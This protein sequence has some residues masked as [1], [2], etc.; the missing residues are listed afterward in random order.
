MAIPHVYCSLED[1]L[2]QMPEKE[3]IQLT[4][5]EKFGHL[6]EKALGRIQTAIQ[7]ITSV[8]DSYARRG[9]YAVPL[10]DEALARRLAKVLV[11]CALQARRN[12]TQEARQKD[13]EA[14]MK[15]L[16]SLAKGETVLEEK[17]TSAGVK[18]DDRSQI[19]SNENLDKF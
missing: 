8:I 6:H 13:Y 14:A 10:A 5:D 3:L 17:G 16:E 18:R 11:V 9:G 15:T 2:D 4:D 7:E 19:F 1:L 12:I